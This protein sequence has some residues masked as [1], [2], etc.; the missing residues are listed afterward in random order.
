MRLQKAAEVVAKFHDAALT[1]RLAALESLFR[2]VSGGRC[3]ASCTSQRVDPTLLEALLELKR[4]AAQVNVA[5]HAV[6]ILLSLPAIL[7]RRERVESLSLGAGNTGRPFD[8]VTDQRLA[9]FKFIRWRGGAESIRQNSLFKDFYGLAEERTRKRKYL[10][11]LGLE[12]PLRFLNGGR[13]LASVMSRNNKLL[14]SFQNKYGT[15]FR[16]VREYFHYRRHA[17]H[18]ADLLPIV[19]ILSRLPSSNGFE[20]P[21]T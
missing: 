5:I 20:Q 10:Y 3:A 14:S 7:K 12:H 4:S 21:G 19:P 13:S 15:R 11:V 17:V 2:G 18:I 6:G 16:A 1:T 8:L 9:E